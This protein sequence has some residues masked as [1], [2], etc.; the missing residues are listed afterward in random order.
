MKKQD[1]TASFSVNA[2][3][4]EAF[5]AINNVRA[6]WTENLEGNTNK[7]NDVFTVHFGS[8]WKTIKIIE[9]K[10]GKKVI[11]HVTDCY[12]PLFN[13]KTEWKDTKV[14]WEI[15]RAEDSTQITFTHV[16]LVP[17]LDCFDKCCIG[18]TQYLQ[19]LQKLIVTGK[20]LPGLKDGGTRADKDP[21]KVLAH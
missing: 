12:L 10:P 19:S 9:V 18:W 5:H 15:S 14:I 8:F 7:L 3:A 4:E 11:W 2:T 6:W 13:N 21:S 17:G 1:F 20:G 16:G